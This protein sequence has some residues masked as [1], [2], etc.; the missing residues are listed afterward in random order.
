VDTHA[1]EAEDEHAELKEAATTG[2]D[3]A[4]DEKDSEDD[5]KEEEE[6]NEEDDIED[7]NEEICAWEDAVTRCMN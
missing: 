1:D 7:T 2:D 4:D 6:D 5:D 3:E